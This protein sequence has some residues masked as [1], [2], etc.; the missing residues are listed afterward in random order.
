MKSDITNLSDIILF[1]DGF[2][3][4]VQQDELIGPIF[5]NV[6]SD[7]TPHLQKMYQFWNAALF[8]VPGFKGNPF[9][10][11]APLPIRAEHFDRWLLLFRETI[12]ENFEGQ[13]A[14]ETKKRAGLM[15]GMFLSRL[16]GLNG[17]ADFDRV[18]V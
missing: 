17:A 18:V 11:H 1:V 5:N 14:N 3:G 2:Y 12:D 7:W 8:A 10:K 6:I 13:M 4:K 15:A 9:A 16:E